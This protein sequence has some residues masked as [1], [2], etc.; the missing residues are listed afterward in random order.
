MI[1][2]LWLYFGV[3]GILSI[4]AWAAAL[5]LF[6]GW[7]RSRQR[8]KFYW[9]ALGLAVAGLLC[10]KVNSHFVSAI[11]VDRSEDQA[12]AIER[13]KELRRELEQEQGKKAAKVRYVEDAPLDTL[14]MAGLSTNKTDKYEAAATTDDSARYAYRQR[15]KQERVV[16]AEA[17]TNET[18]AGI[19]PPVTARHARQ[20]PE[21]DVI[22]AN[23]LDRMNLFAA[24]FCFWLAWLLVAWDYL[25]RFNRTLDHLYPLPVAGRHLDLFWPKNHT[26]WWPRPAST[27]LATYLANVVRKGETF[28]YFGPADPLGVATLPRL[29]WRKWQLWPFRIVGSAGYDDEF[30]FESAWFHRYALMII[31]RS[32]A[33][34]RLAGL[35]A[36]LE[37]RRQTHAATRRTVHVVWD[38]DTAPTAETLTKLGEHCR[39]ANYKLVVTAPAAPP[40]FE[41]MLNAP[42][43]VKVQG[44]C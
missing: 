23:R 16:K 3:I 32:E 41:E 24:R 13:Q 1:G 6:G 43:L 35:L 17:A 36:F 27:A 44:V 40:V 14:D 9:I 30:V 7:G 39:E 4:L 2:K 37:Q 5:V 42:L 15:G 38:F 8:T 11:E 22:N 31:G 10:A 29:V 21:R 33:E 26:V 25:A 19:A 20:L 28:L 34:Q 18:V 12:K